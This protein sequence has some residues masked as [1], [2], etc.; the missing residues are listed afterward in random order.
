MRSRGPAYCFAEA[1]PAAPVAVG[2]DR[3]PERGV[4]PRLVDDAGGQRRA[5]SSPAARR[6][7]SDG[8]DDPA[9]QLVADFAEHAPEPRSD[10]R[11]V[12]AAGVY[13]YA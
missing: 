10:R 1:A 8:R 12:A 9:A 5:G 11:M 13:C 4:D 6:S 3:R 2:G 7:V